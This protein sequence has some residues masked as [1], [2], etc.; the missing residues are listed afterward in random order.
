M[1]LAL[2]R[3]SLGPKATLGSLF[4]DGVWECVTLEDV[5]RELGEDG[6]GKVQNA[7]AI[8]A[9]RYKVITDMSQRFQ[10]IMIHVLDV[11]FF[12]GIRIHSGN[13]DLDTDGCVTVGQVCDG[14]D[15][16]HGGSIE[17]PIL[18]DKIQKALDAG[19]E[20]WIDITNDF[21]AA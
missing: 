13:T 8:P 3:N 10:K 16:I 21:Q 1:E 5:V 2:H 6:S 17:L 4:V 7:T 15:H 12:S 19:D 18:Q 20:V 9:G 14:P 11:P